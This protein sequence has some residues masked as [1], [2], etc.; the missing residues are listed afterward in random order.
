[1]WCHICGLHKYAVARWAGQK[2]RALTFNAQWREVAALTLNGY[3]HVYS[4][5]SFRQTH[6]RKL[7]SCQDL[8]CLATQVRTSHIL[9]LYHFHLKTLKKYVFYYQFL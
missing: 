4:A 1:M 2:V 9:I 6:S 8:V 3:I 5:A 7:P